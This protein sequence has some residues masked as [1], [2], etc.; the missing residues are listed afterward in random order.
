L[1]A[2]RANVA[3]ATLIILAAA[4]NG[5]CQ[6]LAGAGLI[7]DGGTGGTGGTIGGGVAG[8]TAG[9]IL[10]GPTLPGDG[11]SG[12]EPKAVG[13]Y[14]TGHATITLSDGTQVVLDRINRGPHLYEQFGAQ[15]RWSNGA[16]WYLTISGAGAQADMGS[17]YAILDRIVAGR[18]LTISDPAA[19][20]LTIDAANS[21]SLRGSASCR[22]LHWTDAID[23]GMDGT[24][25]DAGL[26]DVSAMLTFEATQ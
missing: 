21:Q 5:G 26:P 23:I 4:T 1:T 11:G 19:C 25:R 15:V 8:A 2:R 7:P 9:P 13:A 14:R 24:P 22:S 18:H 10:P 6:L 16:G 3:V 12:A 20:T 17:P